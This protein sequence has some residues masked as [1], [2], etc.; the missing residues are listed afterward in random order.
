MRYPTTRDSSARSQN[1][2]VAQQLDNSAPSFRQRLYNLFTNYH[3]YQ[4]FSN[5]AWFNSSND[6]NGYDSIESVHDQIH[7]LTVRTKCPRIRGNFRLE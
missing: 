6:P 7:G 3:S 5:E 1:N 2:L 4:R